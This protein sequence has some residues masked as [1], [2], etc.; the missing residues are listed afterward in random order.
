MITSP[1]TRSDSEDRWATEQLEKVQREDSKLMMVTDWRTV[2]FAQPF[3]EK[4]QRH[5]DV[6]KELW[7]Q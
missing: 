7:S 5:R 1:E 4:V 6:V 3:W 2:S